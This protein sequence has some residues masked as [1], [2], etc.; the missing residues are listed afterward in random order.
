MY[1]LIQSTAKNVALRILSAHDTADAAQGVGESFSEQQ[2]PNFIV[3]AK[4]ELGKLP[5]PELVALYNV[6]TEEKVQRFTDKETAVARVLRAWAAWPESNWQRPNPRA[7][8]P[9]TEETMTEKPTEEITTMKPKK[10]APVGRPAKRAAGTI[11][12]TTKAKEDK[13]WH[14]GSRRSHVFAWLLEHN[15]VAM[16]EALKKLAAKLE[17]APG[18]VRGCFGKLEELKLIE[19]RA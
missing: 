10:K 19:L 3:M 11:H 9:A 13:I 8:E 15:G 18:Q 4:A 16:D 12:L 1:L 6:M 14:S 5:G 17:C 2:L 7:V